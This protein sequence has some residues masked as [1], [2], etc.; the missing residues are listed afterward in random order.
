MKIYFYALLCLFIF[1][2]ASC[3]KKLN[4]PG[5]PNGNADVDLTVLSSTMVYAE[6]YNIMTNPDNYLGKT[7][8]AKGLYYSVYYEETD[9]HYHFVLIADAASCCTQG[10]EFIWNGSHVY[11]GDYPEEQAEIEITGVFDS[12][13]ELGNTY[14]YLSVDELL[15]SQPVS[16]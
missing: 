7:I 11:P 16:P 9:A 8:K 13:D 12:Y 15:H 3:S 1:F 5:L 4:N 14:Y 2:T 6:V 10:F